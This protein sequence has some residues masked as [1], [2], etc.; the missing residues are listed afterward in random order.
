[1]HGGFAVER[2]E[3]AY[4]NMR[5]PAVLKYLHKINA[6]NM[7]KGNDLAGS[8][9]PDIFVGSFGYPK[10]YVGPL[11]PPVFGDTKEMAAPEMWIGKGID[12]IIRMRSGLIRGIL[13]MD[14]KDVG[15]G[16]FGSSMTELA[17]AR[18]TVDAE[19]R[20]IRRPTARMDLSDDSQPFGPSA[21]ILGLALESNIR[22]DTQLEKAYS[23][24]SMGASDAIT[25][26]YG[27]GVIIS[28]I[29]KALSAGILGRGGRRRFVP[30]RWSITAVDD[31]IS[32][33]NL[34]AVKEYESIDEFAIYEY[35]ALD[36]RWIVML[37]PGEWS[38]ELVEAWYPGTIWNESGK[39]VAI[40]SSHEFFDGRKKYAEIGGC[41]YAAR[42]AVSELLERR[43]I[44]A[45][46]VI[47][48][49]VHDK[50]ILPVG[51]WNVREHVRETLKGAPVSFSSLH[52]ALAYAG[53]VLEIRAGEWIRNSAILRHSLNQSRLFQQIK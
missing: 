44:Q 35:T 16:R 21:P 3:S 11:I 40:Y 7:I 6:I 23:D 43:K 17:L 25:E 4:K 13:R 12:E 30:T 14:V 22:T 26:L 19:A 24:I 41:Y 32:K 8:S 42:L 38:Y 50:Y 52:D 39:S 46:V 20:L 27:N 10:V 45:R 28:R 51:V 37:L 48:R 1:M 36:N 47:L 53:G 49:E 34:S 2:S 9:P 5:N 18:H 29:Q 15:R 31:T 33:H